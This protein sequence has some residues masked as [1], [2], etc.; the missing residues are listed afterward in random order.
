MKI[1]YLIFAIARFR[2]L[3]ENDV[4]TYAMC[5]LVDRR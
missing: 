3:L 4:V 2:L 5:G 1:E